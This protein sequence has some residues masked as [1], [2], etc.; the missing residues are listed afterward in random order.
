MKEKTHL[1]KIL[2]HLVKTHQA[3]CFD[4]Q[5]KLWSIEEVL[6]ILNGEQV[7]FEEACK[8]VTQ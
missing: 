7:T 6:S 8:L 4:S 1:Q 2:M 3:F 5:G